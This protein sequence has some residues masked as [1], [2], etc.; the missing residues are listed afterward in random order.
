MLYAVNRSRRSFVNLLVRCKLK[1]GI[2]KVYNIRLLEVRSVLRVF[3]ELC[4]ILHHFRS[5]CHHYTFSWDVT[6]EL[7]YVITLLLFISSSE[8]VA[9]VALSCKLIR[10]LFKIPRAHPCALKFANANVVYINY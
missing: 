9:K 8:R 10:S 2:W 1:T 5:T 4:I 7:L 6:V 3:E